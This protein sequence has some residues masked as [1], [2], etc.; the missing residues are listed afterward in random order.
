[1][2]KQTA[3]A[4]GLVRAVIGM[5]FLTGTMAFILVPYALS[6]HPGEAAPKLAAT[7]AHHLS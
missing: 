1:M 2:E 3:L 5:M 4:A 7:T 6:R